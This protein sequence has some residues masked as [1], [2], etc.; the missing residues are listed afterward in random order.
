MEFLCILTVWCW[1]HNYMH[2]S[3]LRLL[4]QK[5]VNFATS[6]LKIN[7]NWSKIN[8]FSIDQQQRESK[9]K[10][11]PMIAPKLFN[12]LEETWRKTYKTSMLKTRKIPHREGIKAY[13]MFVDWN[14]PHRKDVNTSV[15]IQFKMLRDD[16]KSAW[17]FKGLWTAK[18][19]WVLKVWGLAL[20]WMDI[21]YKVIIKT[22]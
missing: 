10:T 19:F 7:W 6:K 22:V 13:T 9:L 2:L 16:S 21:Y 4:Y 3:K 20:L 18:Q 1:F 11:Q 17:K 5:R 14:T 8:Y 15:E 12:A